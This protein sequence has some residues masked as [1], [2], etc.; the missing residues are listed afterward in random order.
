MCALVTAVQTCALPIF[1]RRFIA[2]P[3]WRASCGSSRQRVEFVVAIRHFPDRLR[4]YLKQPDSAVEVLSL[5]RTGDLAE[6]DTQSASVRV[7]AR[8]PRRAPPQ[9]GMNATHVRTRRHNDCP[10]ALSAT[11]P[12]PAPPQ[13]TT[14]T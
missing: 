7:S 13:T 4:P 9:S 14:V 3:H 8:L 6:H 5:P 11:R 10:D 12:P 2:Q 1:P